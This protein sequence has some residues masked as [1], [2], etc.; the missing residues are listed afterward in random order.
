MEGS[1]CSTL[2]EGCE[3]AAG[4]CQSLYSLFFSLKSFSVWKHRDCLKDIYLALYLKTAMAIYYA[5]NEKMNFAFLFLHTLLSGRSSA[6]LKGSIQTS[7]VSFKRER[8]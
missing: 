5:L 2:G 6:T 1:I 8:V 4:V 3:S 7:Q